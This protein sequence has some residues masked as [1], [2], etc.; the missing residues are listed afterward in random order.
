MLLAPH[1]VCGGVAFA[2]ALFDFHTAI[3]EK[4]NG[5]AP[6][7]YLRSPAALCFFL[8]MSV[9]GNALLI[10]IIPES[11]SAFESLIPISTTS[12]I[13]F[14]ACIGLMTPL[15]VRSKFAEFEGRKIGLEH[16]YELLRAFC[17]GRYKVLAEMLKQR[18]SAS[19]STVVDHGEFRHD[20]LDMVRGSINHKNTTYL[21]QFEKDVDETIEMVKEMP[22]ERGTQLIIRLAIDYLSVAAVERFCSGRSKDKVERH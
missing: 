12:P 13:L 9:V 2:F 7:S 8:F 17:I 6:V 3:V 1:L 4:G 16:A 10:V 21:K 19:Y 20:I 14:A 15:I 11:G 18:V 5:T 22:D